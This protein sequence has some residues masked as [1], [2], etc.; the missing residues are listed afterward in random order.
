LNA[1]LLFNPHAADFSAFDAETRRIFDATIA[2][3]EQ[4]R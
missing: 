1:T 3:F 4:R 2:F